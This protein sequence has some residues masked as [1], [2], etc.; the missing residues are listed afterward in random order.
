MV[1]PITQGDHNYYLYYGTTTTVTFVQLASQ[2]YTI[3]AGQA[4]FPN[5]SLHTDGLATDGHLA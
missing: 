1:C 3:T 4:A 2:F 5:G